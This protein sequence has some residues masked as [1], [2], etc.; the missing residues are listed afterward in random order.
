[1][2]GAG[3]KQGAEV[4]TRRRRSVRRRLGP[5]VVVLIGSLALAASAQAIQGG[6]NK[7]TKRLEGAFKLVGVERAHRADGCY[8]SPSRMIELIR[9]KR[10]F[11][12]AAAAGFGGVNG[13]NVVYV[14]KR[15]TSCD[16]VVFA[17]RSQKFYVLD[18][19][20]GPVYVRGQGGGPNRDAIVGNRGPL[21]DISLA[22][23]SFRVNKPDVTDRLEVRCPGGRFPLGGG[24]TTNPAPGS[25][26]AGVYPHSY[27]RLGVQRGYH[28]S[29]IFIDLSPGDATPRQ[30]TI[31]VVCGRGLVPTT[32]PHK[33]V[34]IRSGETRTAIARC[35]GRRYLISGGFQRTNF[36]SPGG[37]YV[38][39]SRSIGGKVWQV[40]GHAFGAGGGELTAIAHCI[41]SKR[42]LLS[43]VAASVP[44]T[45]GQAATATTGSCPKGR[46]LTSGGFSFNGDQDALF[47]G[48]SI[49]RNGSWSATGFPFFGPA[50]SLTAYGYCLRA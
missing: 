42:P 41:K 13:T 32:S 44:L 8:P 9:R 30:S 33:T 26:G 17:T 2:S 23:K 7:P 48:G 10:R 11:P 15:R 49:N 46:R 22:S 36:R 14:I 31:Q 37:N 20:R 34:F 18:S 12:V 24:M 45:G 38:T 19:D 28:I 39:E 29:T 43:E 6:F 47:A 25:D 27:E 5:P 1:M 40:T 35:P 4:R 3:E 16:R 50:E 21:R